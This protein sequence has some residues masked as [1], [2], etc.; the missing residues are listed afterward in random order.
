MGVLPRN[1]RVSWGA[2]AGKQE[3]FFRFSGCLRGPVDSATFSGGAY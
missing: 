1:E 3:I 2:G